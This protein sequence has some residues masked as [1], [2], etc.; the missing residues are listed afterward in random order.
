MDVDDNEDVFSDLNDIVIDREC[1]LSDQLR[2]VILGLIYLPSNVHQL[3]LETATDC[4]LNFIWVTIWNEVLKDRLNPLSLAY[5]KLTQRK[6]K[7]PNTIRKAL[8]KNREFLR[9]ALQHC[10]V[11]NRWQLP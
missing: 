8:L 1:L 2:A 11:N 5:P 6:F 10:F 3:I 7:K 9:R 4:D